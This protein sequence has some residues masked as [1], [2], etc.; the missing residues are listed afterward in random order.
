MSD[1]KSILVFLLLLPAISLAQT[2]HVNK[3]GEINYRGI[4]ESNGSSKGDIYNQAKNILLN[5]I[6]RNPDSLIENPDKQE[7]TTSGEVNISTDYQTIKKFRYKVKMQARDEGIGY[8]IGDVQLI[9]G[10]RGKKPKTIP[11]AQLVKGMEEN[12]AVA[13]ETEK[14]LNAIDLHIQKLIASM[15]SQ[16]M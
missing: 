16:S 13:I 6:N 12:G 4:I 8:E 3:E 5:H 11:S 9:T 7:I 10:K 15:K 1:L 2:I 14:V